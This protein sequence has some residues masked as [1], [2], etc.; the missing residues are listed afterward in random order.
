[1]ESAK[2]WRSSAQARRQVSL[3]SWRL[4]LCEPMVAARP[5]AGARP[6]RRHPDAM[7]PGMVRLL[8]TQIWALQSQDRSLLS[9]R[10]MDRLP[11]T[12][13]RAEINA[14]RPLAWRF[15]SEL[16]VLLRIGD[17]APVLRLA[18]DVGA[19]GN[20]A[21]AAIALG[22]HPVGCDAVRCEIIPPRLGPPLRQR[23][24]RRRR[25]RIIGE[26]LQLD[27]PLR[28]LVQPLHLLVERDA[29]GIVKIC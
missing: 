23:F 27:L 28:I 15:P 7:D 22:Q 12:F 8:R 21:L 5:A 29:R 1:M 26:A 6:C 24:L 18:G 3:P 4:L 10:P 20:Q 17:H 16:G 2:G 25:A 9:R 13:S 14:P 11:L 19:I